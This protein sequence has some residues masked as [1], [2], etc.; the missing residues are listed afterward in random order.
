MT[1]TQLLTILWCN[2]VIVTAIAGFFCAV[3][4]GLLFTFHAQFQAAVV[5][6]AITIA[7]A[8]FYTLAVLL[9]LSM[10]WKGIKGNLKG[11]GN[12]K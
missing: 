9:V 4:F 6:L 2:R 11:G 12:K 8:V 1:F 3:V 7:T 10:M 5:N